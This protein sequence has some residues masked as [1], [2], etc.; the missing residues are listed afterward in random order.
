MRSLRLAS[1]NYFNQKQV[2]TTTTIMIQ[3]KPIS[4]NRIPQKV[5]LIV[6]QDQDL[7]HLHVS[8]IKKQAMIALFVLQS[9][10]T[11]SLSPVAMHAFAKAAVN[12]SKMY[13]HSA[14][15]LSLK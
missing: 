9:L 2:V 13:V 8:M 4:Q 5:D 7:N 10:L 3:D 15:S 12:W 14:E 1:L 6:T 11:L